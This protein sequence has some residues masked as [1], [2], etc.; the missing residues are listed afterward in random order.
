MSNFSTDRM[1]KLL[2]MVQHQTNTGKSVT[3]DLVSGT[4][5]CWTCGSEVPEERI[6]KTVS[7]L[8][9]LHQTQAE[10]RNSLD[11]ELQSLQKEKREIKQKSQKRT[12]LNGKRSDIETDIET[13]ERRIETLQERKDEL[14][15]EIESL[16]AE[17]RSFES[18][19]QSE[20]LAVH[21]EVN[22][23]EF[24]STQ[25]QDRLSDIEAT[26]AEIRESTED[27]ESLRTEREQI[28]ETLRNLRTRVQ[29]IENQA[30]DEFNEHMELVLDL[31]EYDNLERIWIERRDGKN[32]RRTKNSAS[33][34]RLHVVRK[35]DDGTVYEDTID[36]LSESEREVVGLVFALAGYLVH[37][38]NETVPFMLLDSVEA[39]DSNRIAKLVDH[40]KKYT[41]VLVIAL[42]PEDAGALSE[43]YH[44][45]TEI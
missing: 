25:L 16:E 31:L 18:Q 7:R 32:G 38:V 10:K 6:D 39:V 26:I 8:K 21:K 11:T 20:V 34:F 17:I 44:R 37:D 22:E 28:T 1:P 4:T 30:I 40:F 5:I 15:S 13:S 14:E 24:E 36:H 41:D 27:V 29:S 43:E 3:D 33:E 35:T 23:L 19:D 2:E 42:L 9:D 45:V 12:R